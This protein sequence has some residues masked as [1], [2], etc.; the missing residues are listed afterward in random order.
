MGRIGRCS[1]SGPNYCRLRTMKL[2]RPLPFW[3][4]RTRLRPPAAK[5]RVGVAG[6]RGTPFIHLMYVVE[7]RP[8]SILG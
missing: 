4:L 5:D 6:V 7:R 3:E 8:P 2:S 1:H